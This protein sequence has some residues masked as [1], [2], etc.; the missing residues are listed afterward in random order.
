MDINPI[1]QAIKVIPL[2][3]RVR[4]D[5]IDALK[6]FEDQMKHLLGEAPH[7]APGQD[8][9][10][11]VV[12]YVMGIIGPVFESGGVPP[13]TQDVI[14]ANIYSALRGKDYICV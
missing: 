2:D 3:E 7:M 4:T 12:D 6:P 10:R 8:L 11:L 13:E 1:V 5:A 14:G 9:P